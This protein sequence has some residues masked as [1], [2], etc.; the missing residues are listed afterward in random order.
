MLDWIREHTQGWIV[1]IILALIMVPFA[2]FGVNSYINHRSN[3]SVAATVDGENISVNEFQRA[4]R[5][6][7][8]ALTASLGAEAASVTDDPRLRS[9]VLDSL[10][11]EHLLVQTAH[12]LGMVISDRQLA[13]FI[14]TIPAFQSNGHFDLQRYQQ[15]LRSQGLTV[16]AFEQMVRDDLMMQDMRAAFANARQIPASSAQLFMQ[17]YGQRREISQVELT[18]AEAGSVPAA[19]PQAIQAYYAAHVRDFTL[20][21]R[22]RFQYVVLSLDDFARHLP[23]DAAA[24]KQYYTQNPTQFIQPEQRQARHILIA[25]V[26]GDSPQK[27]AAARALAMDIYHKLVA[28]PDQFAALAKQYSADPGSASQGGDLGWFARDAMVK[29]FADTVFGMQP[30]QISA[31]VHT[32]YGYHIIQLEGIRP[33][34]TQTLAEASDAI[35]ASLQKQQAGTR[36]AD[37]AERFSNRVFEQ[38]DQLKPVA[39]SLGLTLQ[40]SAWMTQHGGDT[41]VLAGGKMLQ[42]LFSPDVLVKHHNTEAI[43]VTPNTLVAAHLLDYQPA[44]VQT[45]AEV[46]PQIQTLLRDQ[47]ARQLVASKGNAWLGELRAGKEPD[48]LKWSAFEWVTRSQAGSLPAELVGPVFIADENTL[49]AYVGAQDAQGNWHLV[50]ISRVSAPPA[51]ADKLRVMQDQMARILAQQAFADYQHSLLDKAK[52][53]VYRQAVNGGNQ[54]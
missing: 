34:K 41:A 35:V 50:R 1:R 3:D 31:P 29:P 12:R 39:D 26:A 51:E 5:Q 40:T 10:I 22:A 37:A 45:L 16:S 33:A 23:I 24:V 14:A 4:L 47:M 43:E 8:N 49:P 48:G 2:L 27:Q 20:P 38:A 9:E 21:A 30:G 11:R 53:D 6:Q 42:A 25:S 7:Q 18:P 44:R 54:P 13:A 17:A 15:M 32:E 28:H 46:T 36:F 52:V 19:S